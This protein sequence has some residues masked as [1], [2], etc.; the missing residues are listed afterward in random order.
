MNN[1]SALPT[2][3]IAGVTIPGAIDCIN[4]INQFSRELF[5]EFRCPNIKLDQPDF[6]PTHEAQ[7]ESRWGMVADRLVA[8]IQSLAKSGADFAI[9]PA[10]T[11]HIVIENIQKRSSIPVLNMLEIVSDTCHEN[12]RKTVGVLGTRWTMSGHLYQ[13]PFEKVGITEMIPTDDEQHIIQKAIFSELIPRGCASNE[14]V[15]DLLRVVNRMKDS[16]CDSV[17]LACTELPL[18]LNTDNC[19]ILAFDTT[20]IL[21][22]A[23]IAESVRLMKKSVD[24]KCRLQS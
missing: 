3:G 18:V 8:S 21:A 11:V 12:E 17:I 20:A 6:Y 10:N 24:N 2:I 9:I 7:V 22:Q 14:T 15:L 4:K 1:I 23:A 5:E 16:G 13:K 19:G